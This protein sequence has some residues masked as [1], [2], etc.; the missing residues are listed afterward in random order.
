MFAGYCSK[1][2]RKNI[3]VTGFSLVE[4]AIVVTIMGVLMGGMLAVSTNYIQ[5]NS[6]R[7]TK[8]KL[9]A[10]DDALKTYY[11]R[12]GYL[13][14]PA[15]PSASENATFFTIPIYGISSFCS[16]PMFSAFLFPGLWEVGT[17]SNRIQGG[18]IPTRALGLPDSAMYD[19]WG[20]RFV[21][22][23]VTDLTAGRTD[24][25]N[26]TTTLTNGVIQVV[27]M[28]GN[29]LLDPSTKNI[30]AYVILSHGKDRRGG[31]GRQS[32]SGSPSV[33]CSTT[34]KDAEN[35][36]MYTSATKDN[37][38][39][40]TSINESTVAGNYYDDLVRWRTTT[41]LISSGKGVAKVK[42]AATGYMY[43]SCAIR[44]D[45]TLWCWGY[46][47][48]GAVGSNDTV[49]YEQ[50]TPV[51]VSG[52]G[53]WKK[54]Y[55]NF[56]TMCGLKM[57]STLWCWGTNTGGQVGDGTT[58]NKYVPTQVSGGGSWKF[59]AV[60]YNNVCG[61]KS[62][63]TL[64]C[65][66]HNYY[67]AVGNGSSAA[68]VTVPTQVSGGGTWKS[69]VIAPTYTCA[70]KSDDTLW[71]WG[72]NHVGQLGVGSTLD[73]NIPTQVSGGG[74]WLKVSGDYFSTCGIKLD[75]TLWCWGGNWYGQLGIGSTA[76]KTVPTQVSGGGVWKKL[77]MSAYNICATK[78]N[79][80]MW[81][82]GDNEY[83]V[84]GNGTTTNKY[85]PTAVSGGMTWKSFVNT[86]DITCG[87][88]LDDTLWCWGANFDGN[89]GD[90]TTTDRY[91]PTQV[92]GGGTWRLTDMEQAPI[93]AIKS[94]GYLR[95][96]GSNAYGAVG[97]GGSNT[98]RNVPT[99]VEIR[100]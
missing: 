11:S 22:T 36:D 35:C 9:Q 92:S 43:H 100:P 55:G 62:D 15:S 45:D 52:G 3:S 10:I 80:T 74:T 2:I 30:V 20:N 14:C 88:K 97:D 93:C 17:G 54:V 82:W 23:V 8:E 81:C 96:W 26:Y 85:V 71:C 18:A 76:E 31:F 89:L 46:N 69:V 95:C 47:S 75:G 29:Q 72:Y 6:L 37:I 91:V 27:D 40:D 16:D 78:S 66:G 1:K 32:A 50:R 60:G 7:T 84:L 59:V 67:N 86:Q 4:M 56:Y 42:D 98:T 44:I 12:Y 13:P 57:D 63:D 94:D 64:W 61:I 87:I 24:F 79:D 68:T 70:I 21:Y 39:M 83:G 53:R 38:F 99:F 65:W 25:I 48:D 28:N 90:G 5:N 77:S 34:T 51:Q 49:N 73:K 41:S 33:A 58:V 19:E